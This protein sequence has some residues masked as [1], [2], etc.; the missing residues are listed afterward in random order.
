MMTSFLYL[1]VIEEANQFRLHN[2]PSRVL[3]STY[4]I[5]VFIIYRCMPKLRQVRC[6]SQNP[7]RENGNFD[8]VLALDKNL[9][10]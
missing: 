8:G 1:H 5:S 6:L 2:D 3:D 7:M 9:E 4:Q 10:M